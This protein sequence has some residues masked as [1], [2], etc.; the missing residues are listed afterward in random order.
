MENQT[1]KQ[2]KIQTHFNH[3]KTNYFQV[4]DIL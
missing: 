4:G 2:K 3:N 1:W